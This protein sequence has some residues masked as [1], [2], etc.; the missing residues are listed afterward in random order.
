MK[1]SLTHISILLLIPSILEG[2]DSTV[3]L[4]NIPGSPLSL[5]RLCFVLVGFISLHK[6]KYLKN[7]Q[8]IQSKD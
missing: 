2:I 6:L 4:V 1:I 8:T 7:N 3:L 5:G